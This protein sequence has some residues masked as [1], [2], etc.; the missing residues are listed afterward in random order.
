[1]ATPDDASQ[2]AASGKVRSVNSLQPSRP[3]PKATGKGAESARPPESPA[4]R[5]PTSRAA[6]AA[7]P[8]RAALPVPQA[9]RERFVQ[10]RNHYYF[11]DGTRAFTDRGNRLTTPSENTEV[12]RSLVGIAQARGWHDLN[13]RGTERFRRE[14]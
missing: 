11:P 8:V 4:R 14:V 6:L 3:R 9:V 1:M 5:A 12:I 7:L 10:V 2:S 13:V